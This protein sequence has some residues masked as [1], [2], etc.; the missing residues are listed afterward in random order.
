MSL[1]SKILAELRASA[2]QAG[3]TISVS[4]G[5]RTATCEMIQ[6]DALAVT[7]EH[8]TLETPELSGA[9]TFQLQAAS[10]SLASRINYLLE[11]IAPVEIDSA[12]CTVQMRSNPPQKDDNGYRYYELLLRR[13]GSAALYRYEKQPGQPRA[14]VPA[15]LTHEVIGR[16]V[17]D[18]CQ[19]IDT[20]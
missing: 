17:D 3:R 13:G 4:E 9:T 16:L 8:L 20:I 14:R 7:L 1:S 10:C 12:G 2:G 6:C 15:A 5:R 11:P 18:F 19:T